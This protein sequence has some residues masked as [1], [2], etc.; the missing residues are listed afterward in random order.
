MRALG[1]ACWALVLW[2][3]VVV[4]V[5]AT[6]AAIDANAEP[7][8]PTCPVMEGEPVDPAIFID[9]EGRRVWFCSDV[10]RELFV[11]APEDYRATLDAL[12]KPAAA[13]A[14]PLVKAREIDAGAPG[15][16]ASGAA[17]WPDPAVLAGRL[18]PAAVHL[19][20]GLIVAAAL[21]ALARVVAPRARWC[22]PP[23]TVVFL[24]VLAAPAAGVAALSG[25][26]LA[27]ERPLT[28]AAAELLELHR[29]L[30]VATAW[31][32]VVAAWLVV[33]LDLD[34]QRGW[35]AAAL[36]GLAL[37]V[38]ATGHLGGALVHGLDFLPF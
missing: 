8:N 24:A 2:L 25:W 15:A 36:A 1:V 9:F 12:P 7:A 6:I 14:F 10:A 5:P 23:A 27:V 37:L 35:A 29:W 38:G 32:A 21:A 26:Q 17:P 22:P 11:A 16:G 31:L 4:A 3:V 19:P 30:G 18:H 28:G 34:R 33:R 13:G 20:V